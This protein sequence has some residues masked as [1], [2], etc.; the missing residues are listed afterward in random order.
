MGELR[1]DYGVFRR[2]E[3]N[4]PRLLIRTVVARVFGLVLIGSA[5]WQAVTGPVSV[6]LLYMWLAGLAFIGVMEALIG[7]EW[8][9]LRRQYAE[10]VRYQVTSQGAAMH[11]V[12]GTKQVA[13]T[14]VAR[15]Q[16]GRHAWTIKKAFG[17][18]AF[19]IPRAAFSPED[20][21]A[22]NDFFLANPEF[23]G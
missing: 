15:V 12:R 5:G 23:A 1:V 16:R 8:L 11:G 7:F 20:S 10:P 17:V 18:E 14:D 3:L 21:R 13:W 9:M 4:D 6:Q 22:I 19:V 2:M